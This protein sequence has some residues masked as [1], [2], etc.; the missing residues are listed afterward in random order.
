MLQRMARISG[1]ALALA[2]LLVPAAA[3]AAPHELLT[4]FGENCGDTGKII[5]GDCGFAAGETVLPRG[6]AVN[7]TT[8]HVYIANQGGNRVDEFT[9]WGS[10]VKAF[11]WDVAPGQV[12][13]VQE[14]RVK[15]SAGQFTLTFEGDT[16]VNLA[17]NAP[18]S[19]SQGSGSVEA[20]LNA[21]PSIAAGGG[22]VSVQRVSGTLDGV[23]PFIYLVSFDGGSLAGSDVPQLLAGNG[24]T[25]LSGGNPATQLEANTRADGT[26]GGVG[27]EACTTDSGCQQGSFGEGSGQFPGRFSGGVQGLAIDSDGNVYVFD[28]GN[29]RIQKFDSAGRF[30]WMA[31]AEVNK[32]KSEEVG[33]TEAQRNLCTELSG[34]VCQKG[35][36]GTGDGAFSDSPVASYIAIGPGDTVYVGDLGR[37]EKFNSGGVFVGDIPLPADWASESVRSLAVSST[38]AIY[39]AVVDVVNPKPTQSGVRKL[40]AAGS[41]ICTINVG[42]PTAIAVNASDEVF[43]VA[44]KVGESSTDN[45]D[46]VRVFEEDCSFIE[47]FGTG[48]FQESTGID[49]NP[50]DTVYLSNFTFANSFI[51]AYGE[52]PLEFEAP[53][54]AAPEITAQYATTVETNGAKV[55]AEINPK[56]WTDAKYYVQYGTAD[57]VAG[58]WGGDCVQELPAPPG[59]SLGTTSF[60]EPRKTQ[61]VELP[62]LGPPGTTYVYRFIASSSGGGPTFGPDSTFILRRPE[63]EHPD[64]RVFE[65][66][67]P[68]FKDGGEV[69]IPGPAGGGAEFTVQPQQASPS[70]DIVT[71]ASA[72]AF[73][74]PKSAPAASQY[75]SERE[76]GGVWAT[77][78]INPRFEEGY[79]RDPAVGFSSDLSKAVMVVLEPSLTSDA[80]PGFPNLYIRDNSSGALTALTTSDYS[81]ELDPGLGKSEYCLAYGG[82]SQQLDRVFFAAKGALIPGDPAGKGFNLYEWS[83]TRPAAE[84]LKLVSVLPGKAE[85]P[86][87]PNNTTFG[88]GGDTGLGYYTLCNTRS[89]LLRHAVSADGSRAFWTY[90]GS[91]SGGVKPLFARVNGTETVQIDKPQGGAGPGGEGT[92]WDASVDGSRAFFTDP[93]PL[94]PGSSSGTD[95]YLYEFSK[96]VGQRLTDLT[97]ASTG[98]A[99]ARGVLGA[100]ADGSM[101]YFV[102]TG[103]LASGA[104]QGGFNLYAWEAGAGTR[105]IATLDEDDQTNWAQRSDQQTARVTPDGRHLAFLSKND[106]TGF[107][108]GSTAQVF[109]YDFGAD[110]LTCVS[111]DPTNAKPAG[112][113]HLPGWSTPYQQPRYLAD[114]GSRLFFETPAKLDPED[115]NNQSDVYEFETEGTGSCTSGSPTYISDSSGCVY[116]ISDGQSPAPSY[117]LDASTVGDD[118][119]ISTRSKLVSNDQDDR[120]DV[121]DAKVGGALPPAPPP[122]CETEGCRGAPSAPSPAVVPATSSLHGPG[123]PKPPRCPK[124]K[125]KKRVKGKVR[126]VKR[127][128]GHHK[129]KH[130]G[131]R[132]H[133]NQSTAGG[134]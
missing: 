132:R 53:P 89:A 95:L 104:T 80:T 126:C 34:D 133:R 125:K 8:G 20:A 85:T 60:N 35:A 4:K 122:S 59:L 103:A 42:K 1:L 74:D 99:G 11:G 116:L 78:N 134:K 67:S 19:A 56:F 93:H 37:V 124:G 91:F 70:G 75:L 47:R 61:E 101:V 110:K 24:S 102:A 18:G 88:A 13:E 118:V 66:V 76:S 50:F 33:S 69:G 55:Q 17:F 64:G 10:F 57:C 83:S 25:P 106:L 32:T 27:L 63:T 82:A 49:V 51:L 117:L 92:Y 71:Y 30:I 109:L 39:V 14:I 21:L 7:P 87:T 96:P 130:S 131:N 128:A 119:F 54:P 100:N 115:T 46:E 65:L 26:P 111:C 6:V 81:P 94:V 9:P 45:V 44:G 23:T 123:N 113:A 12:D 129:G 48:D 43:V 22:S 29:L 105:F 120:Y 72:T 114:S 52:G 79:L 86:A 2:M 77:A 107:Q 40:D 5:S 16:T 28:R 15:A 97:P 127:H 68:T 62:N 98:A 90:G 58:G 36:E 31:G 108:S 84:R 112:P 3:T 41:E 121:Y 38:G 73:G